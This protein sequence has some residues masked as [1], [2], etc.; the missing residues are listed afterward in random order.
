LAWFLYFN[1][2]PHEISR[3][4]VIKFKILRTSCRPCLRVSLEC[5]RRETFWSTAALSCQRLAMNVKRSIQPIKR[6]GRTHANEL[7][8]AFWESDCLDNDGMSVVTNKGG[9]RREKK[10]NRKGSMMT[11]RQGGE[12][13]TAIV[14][15]GV[16]EGLRAYR[17]KSLRWTE[18]GDNRRQRDTFD[19]SFFFFSPSR[20]DGNSLCKLIVRNRNITC[21]WQISLA[22]IP[23]SSPQNTTP[24][25]LALASDI[26][27]DG[28][29]RRYV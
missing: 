1:S 13:R 23:L 20:E 10:G 5:F 14:L 25:E 9:T 3:V 22:N 26:L 4:Y 11:K 15:N 19:R 18:K 27:I 28:L 2:F 21:V 16:N 29:I 6:S 12:T 17:H 8:N 24:F 7:R